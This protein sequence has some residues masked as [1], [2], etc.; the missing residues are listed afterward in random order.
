MNVPEYSERI[1]A[2]LDI[3]GF[4]A[5][6]RQLDSDPSLHSELHRALSKIRVFKHS[7]LQ[8][9]TAQSDLQVS[10]FSDSIVIS[11]TADN[12]HGVIFSAI[13]LQANLLEMGILVRGGISSG[14]TVHSDDILYGEGMLAAHALEANAAI[15]PRIVISPKLVETLQPGYRSMFF[16]QDAD[17]LWFINPFSIGLTPPNADDMAADGYWPFEESLKELGKKIEAE[18]ARLSDVGQLAKW[19]WLKRQHSLAVDEFARL[20]DPRFW[21]AWK[22]QE[23]SKEVSNHA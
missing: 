21:H 22:Q 23:K 12:L 19:Q 7:S 11:G 15:Y 6:V 8:Q 20:G 17:G 4:G 10:V 14:R 13:H 18:L 5:L 1:V 16:E 2:F 3:L 9:A